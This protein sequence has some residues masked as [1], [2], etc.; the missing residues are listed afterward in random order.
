MRKW[1]TWAAVALVFG[2]CTYFEGG[3][4]SPQTGGVLFDSYRLDTSWGYKLE[5]IFIDSDGAVWRYQ[6]DEPWYPAEQRPTVVSERDLLQKYDGA[7]RVGSVDAAVLAKMAA[8]IE[9]AAKGRVAREL[10]SFE[11]SGNLDV[12]YQFDSRQR[13]YDQVFLGGGGAWVARNF[14]PEAAELL[15]WLD[16]VKRRVGYE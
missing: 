7:E 3:P 14:S 12:A 13:R 16:E 4:A 15:R 2:G 8:L 6:R 1:W 5:G 10:P 11:R 9:G